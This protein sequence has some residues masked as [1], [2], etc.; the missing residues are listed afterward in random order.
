M[1][2]TYSDTMTEFSL[3]GLGHPIT[4]QRLTNELVL[5]KWKRSDDPHTVEY[6]DFNIHDVSQRS[7]DHQ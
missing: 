3:A 4:Q 1:L 5:V 2:G 7:R 6:G